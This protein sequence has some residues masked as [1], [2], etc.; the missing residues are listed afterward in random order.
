VNVATARLVIPF[1][2]SAALLLLVINSVRGQADELA[3]A[4]HSA[5]WRWIAPAVCL[6]FLGVWLRSARWSLLLPE[7]AVGVPTLFRALVVGF[8]VNNLLPLRMGEVARAYL[9]S[10]WCRVPYGTTVA[11][12]VV[13]RVLDGLSLALLLLTALWLVPAAPGYL[14]AVGGIAAGGFFGGATLLAIAAWRADALIGLATF[15]ARWLPPRFGQV[16]S[17]LAANFARS[18]ALVHDP[19]RLVRLLALSLVAWCSELGLFFALMFS[20]G[21]SGTYP[22]ALLVGS[23]ANFATLLPS[24]PGYAGTF[25]AALTRVAQDSLALSAGIAAAYDIVVHA[26]L[27]L[28]VVLVGTLV[29]WR[30]HIG[31]DQLTHARNAAEPHYSPLSSQA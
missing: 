25:D 23:A 9:L 29:L 5:D 1:A 21:I 13:E 15:V 19:G 14:L 18:L 6:Y 16:L 8:T 2:L 22:Q 10:R 4:L 24:S 7:H 17:S 12:L 28:P 11:S 31:L 3:A 27:F 30:S 20:V 26:T